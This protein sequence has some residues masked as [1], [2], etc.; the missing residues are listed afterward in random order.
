MVG[1]VAA[2]AASDDAAG[3]G[4][5]TAAAAKPTSRTGLIVLLVFALLHFMVVV[6]LAVG[7]IVTQ[8]S[9]AGQLNQLVFD[10]PAVAG[11]AWVGSSI[12]AMWVV[13]AVEC[14]LVV[15]FVFLEI[16][17]TIMSYI[18]AVR[19]RSRVSPTAHQEILAFVWPVIALL[20]LLAWFAMGVIATALN[21]MAYQGLWCDTGKVEQD[22]FGFFGGIPSASPDCTESGAVSTAYVALGF[23]IISVML[24]TVLAFIYQPIGT[25]AKLAA[26]VPA[27]LLAAILLLF[28][29]AMLELVF[30]V[31]RYFY[32]QGVF[33][34]EPELVVA[35]IAW[36]LATLLSLFLAYAVMRL[37]LLPR[38]SRN[39]L[40]SFGKQVP[41][42]MAELKEMEATA[43]KGIGEGVPADIETGMKGDAFPDTSADQNK[44][45]KKV[46]F[47][48]GGSKKEDKDKADAAAAAA[49]AAAAAGQPPPKR[50]ERFMLVTSLRLV[51]MQFQFVAQLPTVFGFLAPVLALSS[52]KI[53]SAWSYI[54]LGLSCGLALLFAVGCWYQRR[55]FQNYV[56]SIERETLAAMA[57][58]EAAKE[59]RKAAAAAAKAAGDT[60]PT[61]TG[62]WST[63]NKAAGKAKAK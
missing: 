22:L 2:A 49:S 20:I 10:E 63:G 60:L 46:S 29:V 31:Q 24:N 51:A 1:G 8:A 9:F 50:P 33:T 57:A 52:L 36:I 7:G 4:P 43:G 35:L 23:G 27:I 6:G 37:R 61:T 44:K 3:Q 42:D 55:V 14:V 17:S 34:W 13:V 54:C 26:L 32:L 58:K 62:A 30:Q 38:I 21:K 11:S 48:L 25:S 45:K 12:T 39:V 18:T 15:L 41:L 53:T 5:V 47:R 19:K 56:L 28:P 40:Q 59:E 16:K